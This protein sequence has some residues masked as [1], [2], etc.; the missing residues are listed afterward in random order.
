[1]REQESC[2]RT[3]VSLPEIQPRMDVGDTHVFLGSCFAE[4]MGNRLLELGLPACVNPVGA[5]YNPESIRRVV[6]AAFS[7]DEACSSV[8]ERNGQWYSWLS[9]TLLS[10]PT[11]QEMQERLSSAL[12]SLS[13][14][15][16]KARNLFLTLGTSV[17]YRLRTDGRVVANCHKM[18]AS[19]FIE[20][21]LSVDECVRSLSQMLELLFQKNPRLRVFFTVS[22]Y[23]YAKYGF[24]GNQLAKSTLLLAVDE[25]CRAWPERTEY[26]PVYEIFMDE[27]RDYR[28]YA[29]DMIHPSSFATDYVWNRFVASFMSPRMVQYIRDMLPVCR[30]Y[31]HRSL[32]PGSPEHLAFL[33]KLGSRVE[34]L[35]EEYGFPVAGWRPNE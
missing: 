25:V 9:G 20:A 13:A 2:F 30:G 12:S 8:F 21:H 14:Y 28:F 34:K 7:A 31:A 33:E 19:G 27:L 26:I 11:C 17:V 24:H 16:L 6:S 29:D 23:R 35:R 4:R 18:D 1:M 10:A 15:L 5:L 32:N 22:P 3:S